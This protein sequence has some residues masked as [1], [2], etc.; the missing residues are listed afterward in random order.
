MNG[1]IIKFSMLVFPF[2][3][4]YFQ[5]KKSFRSTR[6]TA[7]SLKS[8]NCK[9]VM[10]QFIFSFLSVCSFFNLNEYL[11]CSSVK[12]QIISKRLLYCKFSHEFCTIHSIYFLPFIPEEYNV[13]I[14]IIILMLA[15]F[16]ELYFT[17]EF[18]P[19]HSQVHTN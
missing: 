13:S 1:T 9:F 16:I 12:N 8:V 10:L 17:S 14:I 3:Q 18:V 4:L 15:R 11:F 6:T 2:D 7:M 5:G 19:L